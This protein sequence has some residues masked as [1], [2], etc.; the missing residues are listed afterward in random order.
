MNAH[1]VLLAYGVCLIILI[2]AFL[3]QPQV[4]TIVV[5]GLGTCCGMLLALA[6]STGNLPS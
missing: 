3:Q 5:F 1:K 4:E 2:L 6:Y